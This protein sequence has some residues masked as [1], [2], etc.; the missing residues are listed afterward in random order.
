MLPPVM[1]VV[2]AQDGSFAIQS[3]PAG[4]YL[5][6]VQTSG[7]VYLDPC[8]WSASPPTFAVGA[9]QTVAGAV[10]RLGK[11]TRLPIAISDP[12]QSLTANA[13]GTKRVAPPMVGAMAVSGA[14]M[15]AELTASTSVGRTYTVTLPFDSPTCAF[16]KPA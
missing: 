15:P 13:S 6:C 2:T 12:Q 5:L 1:N 11:G 7:G 4:T 16:G 9:G 14:F 8:H 3:L 10:L